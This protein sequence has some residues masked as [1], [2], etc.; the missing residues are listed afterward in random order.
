MSHVLGLTLIACLGAGCFQ[1]STQQHSTF[2]PLNYTSTFR[3]VRSCRLV[4]AHSNQYQVVLADPTFAADPYTSG[5][6][7]LPVGSVV[8]AEQHGSDSSCNSLMGYY[9][10]AKEKP[11]Y[12]STAGDWHWQELDSNQRVSQDG[13]LTT[14]SSCHAQPPCNDYLCSPP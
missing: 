10:M 11:G 8:V 6:Y 7:P 4:V 2:L 5:P 9:L 12:A 1:D 3:T 13:R 14:C